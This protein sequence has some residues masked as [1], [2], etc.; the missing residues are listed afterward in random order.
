MARKSSARYLILVPI[1]LAM[2]LAAGCGG[3]GDG[4]AGIIGLAQGRWGH[5]A[6]LLEDGR[7]LVV[8]GQETPSGKLATAEVYDLTGTW[9]SA[10]S[11]S[12]VR[13][14]AHTATLL[15][16]GRVLVVGDSSSVEVYDPSSGQ[17]SVTGSMS[18]ERLEHTATLLVDGRVLIA[19]GLAG[20]RDL[21]SAEVYDP[22]TGEWSPTG[23]MSEKRQSHKAVLLGDGTV[24]LV[25]KSTAEIY[26]PSTGSWSLTSKLVPGKQRWGG[27]TLTVLVDGRV[28]M[29]G[30]AVNPGATAEMPG[31]ARGA[32]FML[33]H[34][35]PA[36]RPTDK[37]D[38]YDPSTGIWSAASLMLEPRKFHAA[39][40][41]PD[42]RVMVIGDDTAEM[43]DPA[44][45]TWS[46]A[47]ELNL[48][49][50]DWHTATLLEDGTVMV[51]GGSVGADPFSGNYQGAEG[52]T[53][54]ELYKS[55][56]EWQLLR[57]AAL[58]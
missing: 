15:A 5:T 35:M 30:G 44:A 38:I 4:D 6:T 20:R 42:G 58:P 13:G 26:D 56:T 57:E 1:L 54:V 23:D 10:G 9:S 2:T 53:A 14:T 52:L 40:L 22:S 31:G 25:G 32:G 17:W 27:S 37:V 3:D 16:D 34:P 55:A 11:M 21:D 51:V 18:N 43:Y 39:I 19:G 28:L 45:N 41:M 12:E 48:A 36:L 46:S 29:T 50:F 7:V 49:R 33:S 24:L 47:G 8:G